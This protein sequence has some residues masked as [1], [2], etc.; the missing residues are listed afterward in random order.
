MA[1][2]Q[3]R[4]FIEAERCYQT[5][6]R[7]NPANPDAQNLM[8]LL[9]VEAGR[10]SLAVEYIQK[11]VNTLPDEPMYLNN[12]GN[13]LII[14]ARYEEALPHLRKAAR[15]APRNPEVWSNLG[16]NYRFLGE[17]GQA[18][19]SF[20]KALAIAPEFLRARAGIAET[21]SEL[22]NF[23]AAERMFSAILADAPENIEAMCGLAVTRKFQAGDPFVA[24]FEKLLSKPTLRDDERAP[25]HHA[26]AKLCNDV[27]RHDEA[28]SHF[29]AGKSYKKLTFH[30][31]LHRA[32][33]AAMKKVFAG[34]FWKDRE[35]FGVADERPVFIVG[36]PRSGTS[37]TEQVL[38]SHRDIEGLGELPDLRK[39]AFS[40]GFGAA[41]SAAFGNRIASLDKDGVQ[42][43]ANTYLAAYK[44]AAPARRLIDK[45]P[46]NY[47]LLGFIALLFP[48]AHIIHCRREPMDNCVAIFMQNFSDSHG[49][50]KDLETLGGYFREYRELMKHWRQALPLA[51]HE[52]NYET[53]V[54]D[55]E[56][57][58]RAMVNFLG[59]PWDE[60]CLGYHKTER[61]VRTPS[62]WQVRQPIYTSSVGR[63]RRYEKHLGP[64]KAA[65]S[66]D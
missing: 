27:G 31:E 1:L 10:T 24:R 13:A 29:Q 34:P 21:E 20:A 45:S 52:N 48:R 42:G 5:V 30:M 18:R 6:L 43:L 59:L 22:G 16:K 57:S 36:M 28:F 51:I 53:L 46:H 17:I 32:T 65:L 40:L 38:A 62:R 19:K 23:E 44:R 15:I 14:A 25:L 66:A 60:N 37:L 39:L 50:N 4:R 56:P 12:L 47:E 49:Y 7:E 2:Q 35:G 3:A 54:A 33:Y 11:A 41:D 55:F 63:W 26:F 9:A 64:L 61:Q 58:V 8:G